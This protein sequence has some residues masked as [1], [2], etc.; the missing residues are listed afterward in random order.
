MQASRRH[1]YTL[2]MAGLLSAPLRAAIAQPARPGKPHKVVIQV[3]D[4]DPAKWALALNNASNIQQDL[5]ADQVAIEIVAYGPGI[6]LLKLESVLGARVS[7]AIA[8]GVSVQACENTLRNQKLVRDDMLP[9]IGYV[10]SGVVQLMKRQQEG[11]A[12][13][14]P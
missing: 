12:Y 8:A 9:R 7:E 11:Y 10:P 14:R 1:L 2:L 3:S 5:G 6:G 4:A 13:I